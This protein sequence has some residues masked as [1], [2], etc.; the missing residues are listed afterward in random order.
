LTFVHNSDVIV[1]WNNQGSQEAMNAKSADLAKRRIIRF[2]RGLCVGLLLLLA[3]Q[4]AQAASTYIFNAWWAASVDRDQDGCF[5][6]DSASGGLR[7]SWD[8]DVSGTET[9]AVYE[10]IYLRTSPSADWELVG[11]TPIHAITANSSEDSQ[12]YEIAPE[13]SC[14]TRD[15]RI[16]LYQAGSSTLSDFRD[17][18]ND[19]DLNQHKE[20]AYEQD[21]PACK[22]YDASWSKILD[23]D[24]D[25]CWAP[26]TELGGMR[27]SWDADVE[28]SGTLT[29]FERIYSRV[30]GADKWILVAT[31]TPHTITGNSATDA[32]NLELAPTPGC[33]MMEYKIELYRD[34]TSIPDYIRG[35]DNDT[36]LAGRKEETF[37]QD[38]GPVIADAWWSNTADNSHDGCVAPES[39]TGLLR[40]NWNPNV[41]GGGTLSVFER[42]YLRESGSETWILVHTTSAHN[43]TGTLSTDAQ[44]VDIAP[45]TGC[46]PRDYRI[47][48][49]RATEGTLADTRDG[50]KDPDLLAHKEQSYLDD[51]ATAI[52]ADAWWT[53]TA[54]HDGDG[55]VAPDTS[56]A[57]FKLTWNPDV[58]AG[59]SL[60]VY[61]KLW[62]RATGT[63][64]WTLA[65]TTQPHVVTGTGSNDLQQLSLSPGSSCSE[66]DYRI[67]IYRQGYDTPDA[68]RDESNDSDLRS[69]SEE[70]WSEDNLLATVASVWWSNITDQDADGCYA[71]ET[72]DTSPVLNWNPN[73]VN[74]A[75]LS[76]YEKVYS[77][78]PGAGTWN[79]FYISNPH[80]ITGSATDDGQSVGVPILSGC[81]AAE[82]RIELYRADQFLPD[83][84]ATPTTNPLLGNR[85]QETRLEDTGRPT[86]ASTW[87]SNAAD[88]DGDGCVAP[89]LQGGTLRLNWE[90]TMPG[91]SSNLV[92]ERVYSRPAGVGDYA[93]AVTNAPHAV[94]GG[95]TNAP[96][97]V[98]I[99]PPATCSAVDYRIEVYRAGETVPDEVRDASTDAN[100]A[101]ERQEAY[102]QDNNVPFI[103]EAWW[104]NAAD[105]DLDG[106]WAP[107]NRTNL[108]RLQWDPDLSASGA[109]S[110][111]EK[112]YVR[113]TGSTNW[114]LLITTAP[115]IVQSGTDTDTQSV[116]FQPGAGCSV[117]DYR[118]EIFREG[119]DVADG[120]RG[121][122]T[123]PD[124]N[125]R[126]EELYEQD[127]T[128]AIINNTW[129]SSYQDLDNDDCVAPSSANTGLRLNWDPDVAGPGD[130]VVIEHVYRRAPGSDQ[131][132]LLYTST[133]HVLSGATATDVQ[134]LE[135]AVTNACGAADY[136]ID[137]YRSGQTEP[138]SVR[139]YNN[140]SALSQHREES[141]LE[142]TK[143]TTAHIARIWWTQ[144]VDKDGDGCYAPDT[145]NGYMRLHWDADAETTGSLQVYAKVFWRASPT[146][147][148]VTVATSPV[149]TIVSTNSA[150]S[151]SVDLMSASGCAQSQ[152]RIELYRAGASVPD[153]IHDP[154][155][156]AILSQNEEDYA[157]DPGV[158]PTITAQ[159]QSQT[160]LPGTNVTFSV[161]ATGTKPFAYQ[162]Y[163]G[164]VALTGATDSSL[165]LNKVQASDAGD[166]LAVVSNA[167]GLQTS[168]VAHLTIRSSTAPRLQNPTFT[169]T[170]QF[171]FQIVGDAGSVVVVE[172]TS[173]LFSWKGL[174]TVTNVTGTVTFIDPTTSGTRRFYRASIS[175]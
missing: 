21:L 111:Y 124:L 46:A 162:W 65:A 80:Q 39:L 9:V 78:T 15:Y 76:V 64:T 147:T 52:I 56:T 109:L 100:L 34:G 140:D 160:V 135:I 150:D 91:T 118:I 68:A 139:D 126:K 174:A 165:T 154:S 136:R 121:P 73:V 40:L 10:K 44:Y 158:A 1:R 97:W 170:G 88:H 14:G 28:G 58:I 26:E 134:S 151:Q 62:W 171:Q 137:I 45:A 37:V 98:D 25:G 166:Y 156:D 22:I 146:G 175:P 75:T 148:W 87:W 112:I 90:V 144:K 7:L 114:S 141:F 13:V 163:K 107:L 67:E 143:V 116:D 77:R 85:K 53:S 127:N 95:Q 145:P 164:G 43:I 31:T 102:A 93:L 115:H 42:I 11:T 94:I 159:P 16:E 168:S 119:R 70:T 155:T 161:T 49:Y 57:Y 55:C 71:P 103:A 81:A 17:P 153:D 38:T 8:A 33:V 108:V 63:T 3:V 54:D 2:L 60:T 82:Y 132:T 23:R 113:D 149:Q 69:H 125:S 83:D 35:P 29:V 66:Y 84:T 129:W 19:N 105:H 41:A 172:Y 122:E 47:E 167:I 72:A 86:I 12:Y 120:S 6:P 48:L 92:F 110:A 89:D 74:G 18:T 173:T 5:A 99:A 104:A 96:A 24:G 152:Y 101:Q 133:P 30:V 157:D 27:L 79:L 128:L 20:E 142:D 123:D 138:D 106:C 131:W 32:Q 169:S 117:R 59:A 61:E 50:S 130:L 36:D 51:N 4:P